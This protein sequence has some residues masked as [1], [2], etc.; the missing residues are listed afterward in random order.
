MGRAGRGRS[1]RD[2][3]GYLRPEDVYRWPDEVQARL[4]VGRSVYELVKVGGLEVRAFGRRRFVKGFEV[5]R[6]MERC[7]ADEQ[8][9]INLFRA[10]GV[11]AAAGEAEQVHGA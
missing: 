8:Q 2:C 5:I 11:E 4:G 3:A 6:A 1:R 9:P 7:Y 10:A